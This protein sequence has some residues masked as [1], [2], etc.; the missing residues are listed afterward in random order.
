MKSLFIK[1]CIACELRDVISLM[2]PK[3]NT[4]IY[5]YN[6]IRYQSSKMWNNLSNNFKM[7]RGFHLLRNQYRNGLDQ[8]VTVGIVC[9][10]IWH[11]YVIIYIISFYS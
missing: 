9:S 7:S 5:S 10:A 4:I 2:Q 11:V 1:K 8:S 3:F 6:T